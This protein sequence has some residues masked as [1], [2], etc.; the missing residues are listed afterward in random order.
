MKFG[1]KCN[2]IVRLQSVKQFI[3]GSIIGNPFETHLIKTH[4]G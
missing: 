2:T 1:I 3:K 4:L